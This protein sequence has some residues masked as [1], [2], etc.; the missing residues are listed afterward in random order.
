M[1]ETGHAE[2]GADYYDDIFR[3]DYNEQTREFLYNQVFTKLRSLNNPRVLEIGCG[4]GYLA[5]MIIEKNIPY[6]GFDFSGE[7]IKKA[8]RLNPE[9]DFRVADAYRPESYLPVD[10]NVVI[11][12]EVLEHVD[13]N[14]LLKNLPSGVH[15]IGTVPDFDDVAHLRLYTDPERDIKQRY[16][17]YM[18][19][20]DILKIPCFN[21]AQ[22]KNVHIYMFSGVIMESGAD[23][24]IT[25]AKG[26]TLKKAGD[27]KPE[28]NALRLNIGCSHE[29]K[30][31]WVNIDSCPADNVDLVID[32]EMCGSSC[33]PYESN[34]VDEIYSFWMPARIKNILPLMQE[35]HRI[36][37]NNARATFLVPYGSSDNAWED[38]TL[39]RRFFLK[40]FLYFSQACLTPGTGNYHGDWRP[41]II[42]L[43]VESVKYKNGNVEDIAKDIEQCRNIVSL[44][45]VE[46]TAVKPARIAGAGPPDKPLYRIV[47]A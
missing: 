31:G 6:R 46:M 29:I 19:V 36:A 13:D 3:R 37:K 47:P 2:K 14:A 39:V 25:A 23:R 44:M 42:E 7:A 26:L 43:A 18:D 41:E 28:A 20:C 34:S 5:R 27:A 24:R 4:T 15:F 10:Y 40:S 35:L 1:L 9:G 30:A 45:K 16:A 38:P 22:K 32:L 8:S 21:P 33:L 11:C 17:S 12:M